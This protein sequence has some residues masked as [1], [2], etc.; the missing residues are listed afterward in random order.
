MVR[1]FRRHRT[2][3]IGQRGEYDDSP[4]PSVP[5]IKSTEVPEPGNHLDSWIIGG[6]YDYK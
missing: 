1:C 3:E 4:H 5:G 2:G 6:T